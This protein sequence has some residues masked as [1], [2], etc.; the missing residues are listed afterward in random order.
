MA[1]PHVHEIVRQTFHHRETLAQLKVLGY[2]LMPDHLHFIARFDQRMGMERVVIAI[3]RLVARRANVPWQK[4]FFDH[5]IRDPN[6]LR[7]IGAYVRMNPVRAGLVETP[8]AWPYWGP[9]N[10]CL[11]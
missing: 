9:R 10:A 1:K 6:H 7:E 11:G 5:R 3:K 8:D 4:G 2:V